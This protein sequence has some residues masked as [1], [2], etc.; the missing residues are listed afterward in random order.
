MCAVTDPL[1]GDVNITTLPPPTDNKLT[2]VFL[3]FRQFHQNKSKTTR[4]RTKI[5]RDQDRSFHNHKEDSYI[6]HGQLLV[7]IF[8]TQTT[9]PL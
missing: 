3:I 2:G 7:R 5:T 9:H 6:I 1:L 8:A 4:P